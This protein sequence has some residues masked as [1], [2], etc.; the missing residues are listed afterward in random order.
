MPNTLQQ[1]LTTYSRLLPEFLEGHEGEHVLIKGEEVVGFWADE[2]AAIT[3]GRRR[4]P[5][6]PF[7]VK[8][9]QRHE[10]PVN[11]PYLPCRS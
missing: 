7:L 8:K 6:Q 11:I 1:E 9:V 3:E 4:F 10:K 2:R 5:R